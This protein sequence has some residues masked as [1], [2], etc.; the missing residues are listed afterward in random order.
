MMDKDQG[1]QIRTDGP[2]G[3]GN[4]YIHQGKACNI[5]KCRIYQEHGKMLD[6]LKAT[7]EA[8]T[9]DMLLP[10]KISVTVQCDDLI[11]KVEKK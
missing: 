5:D 6:M 8:L 10:A 9:G 1:M 3:I 2:D 11:K 4:E 7:L